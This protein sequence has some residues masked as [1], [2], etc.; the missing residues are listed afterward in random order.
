M[1]HPVR[2]IDENAGRRYLFYGA[3]VQRRLVERHARVDVPSDET[4]LVAD[5]DR[6]K[7][8]RQ[9]AR[10]IARLHHRLIDART[11]VDAAEQTRRTVCRLGRSEQE[12]PTWV[13]RVVKGAAHLLLQ[14]SIEINEDIAAGNQV[15]TRERRV[16]EQIVYGEQ[17]HGAQFLTDPV[18]GVF[19]CKEL[20]QTFLA[21]IGL[22]RARIAPLPRD[23]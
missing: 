21:D 22:D 13:Q 12:K 17:D 4:R 10:L 20:A 3:T 8:S 9:K 11:A 7:Q 16:R 14:I 23:C 5:T 1:D 19:A 2:P 6:P 18:A 15:D